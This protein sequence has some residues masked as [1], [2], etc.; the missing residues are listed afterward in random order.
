MEIVTWLALPEVLV[1]LVSLEFPLALAAAE[2][3]RGTGNE[4]ATVG[5][6]LLAFPAAAAEQS[7]F[8]LKSSL[9]K[10]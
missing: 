8:D 3:A 9:L 4:A 10:S 6:F 1:P 5:N 7:E 2:M